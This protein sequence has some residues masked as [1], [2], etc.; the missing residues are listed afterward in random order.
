MT[1]GDALKKPL[2]VVA[3]VIGVVLVMITAAEMV[4]ELD[5]ATQELINT[6]VTDADGATSSLPLVN[7]LALGGIMG[8]VV[9]AGIIGFAYV[10]AGRIGGGRK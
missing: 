5:D 4:P 10:S 1:L 9:I 3:I 6:N 8:L 7:L 2:A